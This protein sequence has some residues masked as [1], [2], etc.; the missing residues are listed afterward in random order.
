MMWQGNHN[1]FLQS[2]EQERTEKY[3]GFKRS[4]GLERKLTGISGVGSGTDNAAKTS[5]QPFSATHGPGGGFDTGG[6]DMNPEV[7][8]TI[9]INLLKSLSL[10]FLTYFTVIYK[11]LYF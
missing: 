10:D 5:Y 8:K 7:S 6:E 3:G 1:R 4:Q 2:R 9:F 11:F